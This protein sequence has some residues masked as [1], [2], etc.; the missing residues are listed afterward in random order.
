MAAVSLFWNTNMADM[1]SRENV[2]YKE[3]KKAFYGQYVLN[4]KNL[5]V[6]FYGKRNGCT[7]I[8]FISA[9]TWLL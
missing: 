9:L 1:T 3:F 6:D 4:L 8:I 2:L 5:L 7:L